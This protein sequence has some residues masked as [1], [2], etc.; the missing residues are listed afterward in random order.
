MHFYEYFLLF[1]FV[2]WMAEENYPLAEEE[3]N[4]EMSE[5][6][7]EESIPIPETNNQDPKINAKKR[8]TSLNSENINGS[9]QNLHQNVENNASEKKPRLSTQPGEIQD[10]GLT[11]TR[12]EQYLIETIA[13]HDLP[14]LSE[15]G[16]IFL[17][18]SSEEIVDRL[19]TYDNCAQRK[20]CL[21][22]YVFFISGYPTHVG[23]LIPSFSSCFINLTYFVL[24]SV[25]DTAILAKTHSL[26][27]RTCKCRTQP[28]RAFC[29]HLF[30]SVP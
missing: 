8:P 6:L 4:Q 19:N 23:V 9:H 18:S 16:E 22:G 28:G 24:F 30:T 10:E 7:P 17:Q 25:I 5:T 21:S 20:H 26:C 13:L 11:L 3:D 1:F 15:E 27:R 14:Q 29:V 2:E 12:A